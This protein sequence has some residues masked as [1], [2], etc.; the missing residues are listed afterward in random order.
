VTARRQGSTL[1]FPSDL[2]VLITRDFEAPIQLVFDVFTKAEHMIN[3]IAPFGEDV[4]L[5]EI[6]LRVGGEYHYIFVTPEGQAM[7]FRGTFLEIEPPT[8]TVQ[9][10]LY[11]GWPDVEAVESF[12]LQETDGVTTMTYRLSFADQA[13][14]DHM[15][16][17]DGL[18]ANFDNVDA[19]LQ[20]LLHPEGTVSA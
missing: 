13:G 11:D 16:K 6:D 9:T 3:T 7:S 10:W 1:E 20:S 19:Y 14:R 15:K 2:D 8:R 4:T 12:D 17:F 18:Q 5:C